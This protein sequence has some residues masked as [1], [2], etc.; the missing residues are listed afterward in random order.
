ML[1]EMSNP[2]EGL[3]KIF[4]QMNYQFI[5]LDTSEFNKNGYKNYM[6]ENND[7]LALT[8]CQKFSLKNMEMIIFRLEKQK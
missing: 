5:S 1:L 2:E 8:F 4:G 6:E 3:Q 7:F